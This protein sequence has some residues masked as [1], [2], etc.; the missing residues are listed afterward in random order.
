MPAL[1]G[2][3]LLPKEVRSQKSETKFHRIVI[4]YLRVLSKFLS[5]LQLVQNYSVV[6]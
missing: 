3:L 4:E 1:T 2:I 5:V 6:D